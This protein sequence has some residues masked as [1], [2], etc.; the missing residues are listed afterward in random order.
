MYKVIEN[1]NLLD[2]TYG[3]VCHQ[4]N[5]VGVMGGGVALA[6]RK[7]WPIVYDEYKKECDLFANNPKYLLGHIQDI[8]ISND[9]V[10]VNCFGQIYP[11]HNQVMTD[12]DA[13]DK[14]LDKLRD[15]CS[16]YNLP[17]HIPYK[18]G[19]G[20]AGGDWNIMEAKFKHMFS[21]S[22]IDCYVHKF[23]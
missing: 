7:K 15:E 4:T 16:F 10:V 12:Y 18:I 11:G 22:S 20:L 5:C 23:E 13:W 9:L 3:L 1:S 2:V 14:I 19:C 6:I 17:I 8:V 21:N